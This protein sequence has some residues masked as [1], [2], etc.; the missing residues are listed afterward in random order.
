[1]SGPE[2]RRQFNMWRRMTR[3]E[4]SRRQVQIN[5][6]SS[7]RV[8]RHTLNCRRSGPDVCNSPS[9]SFFVTRW[10]VVDLDL[11]SGTLCLSSRRQVQIDDSSTCDEWR[12]RRVPDVMSRLMI[13]RRVTNDTDSSGI[14]DGFKCHTQSWGLMWRLRDALVL[15]FCGPRKSEPR[16]CTEFA[17]TSCTATAWHVNL[18]LCFT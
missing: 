9:A 17:N 13:V 1:M 2:W 15:S 11:T 14:V 5:N 18:R 3:T 4:S 10:T 16:S 7:V 8:I 12:G 6:S